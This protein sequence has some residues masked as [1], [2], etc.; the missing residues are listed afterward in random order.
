[1][2]GKEF[3]HRVL[4]VTVSTLIGAMLVYITLGFFD[5]LEP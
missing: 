5:L 1:M 2:T 3:F 4:E